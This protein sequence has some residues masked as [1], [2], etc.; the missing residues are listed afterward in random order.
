[1]QHR[2][3]FVDRDLALYEARV[4]RERLAR[5]KKQAA[6]MGFR[7]IPVTEHKPQPSHEKNLTE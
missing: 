2:E 5:L 1:V 4:H 6:R 3:G 7:L